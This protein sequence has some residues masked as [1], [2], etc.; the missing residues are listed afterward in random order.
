MDTLRVRVPVA[1][2]VKPIASVQDPPLAASVA[3][4][5]QV[6]PV[7]EKSVVLPLSPK[8]ACD[9]I[10]TGR[11]PMLLSVTVRGAAAVPTGVAGKTN[12]PAGKTSRIALFPVSEKYRLSLKSNASADGALTPALPALFRPPTTVVMMPVVSI[13]RRR[14]FPESAI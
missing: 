10:V 11:L 14:L 13:L 6:P 2:G 12:A 3:P 9:A 8:L 5:R 4:C 1:V 7:K